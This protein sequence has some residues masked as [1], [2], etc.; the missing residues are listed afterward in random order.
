MA[1]ISVQYLGLELRSPIIVSSSGLTKNIDQIIKAYHSG[2]GAV[3]L[4]SLFEEQ[5]LEEAGQTLDS[6]IDYPEAA[7]YIR[8]YSRHNSVREYIELIK[9]ARNEIDIPVIASINCV[10]NREWIDFAYEIQEAGAHALELNMHIVPSDPDM[11]PGEIESQYFKIVED[12]KAKLSI[13]IAL[14]IGYHFSNLP[15]FIK[16]LTFRGINTFVLFNR[17]YEPDI[18]IDK[19]E[20]VSSSVF[21]RDT[22]I[23]HSLRWVGLISG[24]LEDVSISAST[25]I[26]DGAGV[27]KQILAG[28]QTVQLCSTLYKNG[29]E[30]IEEINSEIK[31]WMQE[32]NFNSLSDFRGKLSYANIEDPQLYERAQFMKYFSSLE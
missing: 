30:S 27:I 31:E 25:G 32:H 14:K 6:S 3:V 11:K 15:W 12:I 17:F 2:A 1:N 20:L 10:S 22:D 7:D 19:L 13:P 9:Q 29:M 18:N 28:A 26:H 4:K 24:L 21:S 8:N 5:I 16:Q 23:R